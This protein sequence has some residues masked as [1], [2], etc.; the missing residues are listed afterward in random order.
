MA[1]RAQST[2][3]SDARAEQASQREQ[4]RA[5][6]HEEQRQAGHI[7]RHLAPAELCPV[8]EEVR[9]EAGQSPIGQREY[10]ERPYNI[11]DVVFAGEFL[12]D[13]AYREAQELRGGSGIVSLE[14]DAEG[15]WLARRDIVLER[16][17]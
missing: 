14:R 10:G 2:S 6:C 4:K 9:V 17:P 13:R 8:E 11:D 12:V 1:G 3:C 5:H 15:R 16:H 7:E